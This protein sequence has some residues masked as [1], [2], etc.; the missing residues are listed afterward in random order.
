MSHTFTA[1][2]PAHPDYPY[3]PEALHERVFFSQLNDNHDGINDWNNRRAKSYSKMVNSDP[4]LSSDKENHENTTSK[5]VFDRVN[6]DL[7]QQ[8]LKLV[9]KST[10]KPN[11]TRGGRKRTR[12]FRKKSTKR[13]S[14]KSSYRNSRKYK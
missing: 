5:N 2:D 13:R 1:E 9:H 11:S 14:R 10:F 8:I 7:K 4:I 6:P 12:I 3:S